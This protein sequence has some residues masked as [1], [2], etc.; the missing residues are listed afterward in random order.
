M[1]LKKTKNKSM[2]KKYKTKLMRKRRYKVL[3]NK[4]QILKKQKYRNKNRL[5]KNNFLKIFH[6]KQ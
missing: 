4:I 3:K 1:I 5:K 2:L 6:N